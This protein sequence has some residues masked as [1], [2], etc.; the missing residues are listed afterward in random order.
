MSL[1]AAIAWIYGVYVCKNIFTDILCMGGDFAKFYIKNTS[2][3][4]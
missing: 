3:Q 4:N 2:L 1:Y